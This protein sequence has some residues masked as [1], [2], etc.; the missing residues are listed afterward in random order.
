[1]FSELLAKDLDEI[2]HPLGGVV[3]QRV[4]QPL[5]ARRISQ[6]APQREHAVQG[7]LIRGQDAVLEHHG[8]AALGGALGL[9]AG[10]EGQ[11]AW[12]RR[13]QC[14]GI[15]VE[16]S[17]GVLT[18]RVRSSRARSAQPGDPLSR[19]ANKG[20]CPA[21]ADPVP[22]SRVCGGRAYTWA[23]VRSGERAGVC[24]AM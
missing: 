15:G 9:A 24:S 19:R 14:P 8:R 12:S 10:L 22:V 2:E 11:E 17:A 6:Q 1:M 21:A 7:R 20:S 23:A 3:V 5:V 16:P 13:L 18:V 4:Q